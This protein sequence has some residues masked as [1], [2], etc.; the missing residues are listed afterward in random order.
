MWP[1]ANN[2][3]SG[4][5][6]YEQQS[7]QTF[8]NSIAPSGDYQIQGINDQF[9]YQQNNP[10]QSP[11]GWTNYTPEYRDIQPEVTSSFQNIH[12][13]PN[14]SEVSG[15]LHDRLNHSKIISK[16]GYSPFERLT[17]TISTL[18]DMPSKIDRTSVYVAEKFSKTIH[19]VG[20]LSSVVEI[21]VEACLTEI[22]FLPIAGKLC[23]YLC[24]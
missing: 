10:V 15:I 14:Q 20:T 17:D 24:R 2:W 23:H 16:D 12:I 6:I 21:L 13:T 7:F 11:S 8:L 3:S 18:K 5:E 9:Q 1:P 19:D 22:K 4:H